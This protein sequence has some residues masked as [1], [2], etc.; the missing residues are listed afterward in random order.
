M[1][2]AISSPVQIRHHVKASAVIVA[3]GSG[4]R[5]GAGIPKQFLPV[6]G[7]PLLFYTLEKF[8]GI[9]GEIILVLP[10]THITYWNDL[11]QT[12][13]FDV[14]HRVVSGGS[15]RSHSVFS[16]LKALKP[17][18][19]VAIHD[20]VRPLVSPSLIHQLLQVATEKGNAIPVVPARDSM[21]QVSRDHSRA[22]NREEFVLVQTPQC[23]NYQD[24]MRLYQ[25]TGDLPFSDDASLAEAMGVSINLVP[26]ETQNIKVTFREDLFLAERILI[27]SKP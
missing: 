2:H 1:P 11:C 4:T 13:S 15:S 20:A 14:P 8:S 26:G 17:C 5:M 16:G 6:A 18:R 9:D 19:V 22:V 27:A 24:I 25:A 23:F 21:R 3:G 7:R 12:H 10:D